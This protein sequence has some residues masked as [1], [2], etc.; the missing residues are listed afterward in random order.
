MAKVI[1]K[2]EKTSVLMKNNLFLSGINVICYSYMKIFVIDLGSV[3]S[4]I[5]Q[6]SEDFG[7]MPMMPIV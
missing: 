3:R 5:H 1:I 2:S 6:R 7:G 4:A